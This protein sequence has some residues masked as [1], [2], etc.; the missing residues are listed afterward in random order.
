MIIAAVLIA[1]V[2]AGA[3]FL[4]TRGD[5]PAAGCRRASR[6]AGRSRASRSSSPGGPTSRARLP[7]RARSPRAATSRSGWPA[8]A[9]AS[10][11]VYVDAGSWVREGQVLAS[12][13]RSV[14]GQEAEQL[15]AQIE[16]ARADAALAQNELDRSQS[17]V[18]RGF[19]C[20]AD[21]DR[22]RAARDAANARVRVAQATLGANRA[23]IGR[24]D[25]RAPSSGLILARNVEVGQVVGAGAGALFRLASGGEMEMRA[26]MSQQDIASVR[27]GMPASV[28]PI[29]LG[30]S[31]CRHHLASLAGDRPDQPPGRSAHCHPLR[32]R[33]PPRRLRRGR[34]AAGS[35][36]APLLPQS[37]VL[38]DIKGNYVY[39]VNAQERGRTARG[40][41]R[42]GRQ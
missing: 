31:F 32:S 38:S 25:I 17:L 36:T 39:V 13:D 7:R 14:Q 8:K 30:R 6:A 24:L 20:K 41:G 12:I 15:A 11:N 34:I 33:D 1:V 27:T 26:A 28:T 35:T 18:G 5:E 4:F 16:V 9:G 23:R 10:R 3:Y 19:V 2:L 22:K 40:Q 42:H 29:G 21:L 37:A